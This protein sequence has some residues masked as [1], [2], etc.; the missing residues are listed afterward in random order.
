MKPTEN[1]AKIESELT[2]EGIL[3]FTIEGRL[4]SETTGGLWRKTA[5][6]L[7]RSSPT[8]L[9]VDTTDVG[10]CDGS[11]IALL[12]ELHRR[13]NR[14]GGAFEIRN[15]KP[16]FSR[17]LSFFDSDEFDPSD[18]RKAE[19]D[20]FPEE[21]GKAAYAF[22]GDLKT[23]VAFIGEIA[24]S[25]TNAVLHPRSIRW[26]D[27]FQVMETAGVNALPIIA[28]IGF[29]M[30]LILA[31]QA[32]IPMGQF[33]ADIYVANLVALSMLRELGPLMTAIVLAGR[34][35]SAFAAE[36]GTMKVNEEIDALTTM[37]IDPVR[38]LI[39]PRIIAALVVT[40][41]LAIYADLIGLMG[42]SLVM[43]SL[44]FPLITY[45]NQVISAVTYLD[46]TGGLIKSF[47]FGIVVS[48]IGCFRGLQTRTGASAVGVSTTRSVVTGI[49]LIVFVDG[50]FSIVYY[51]LGI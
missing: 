49:V 13:Q 41:L 21:L 5:E 19:H 37:G 45:I 20:D 30:G 18:T 22:A 14:S 11:G 2:P 3:T 16:E 31:F 40:P 25:L 23:L 36:L 29:I 39:A 7:D 51:Y 10:Y 34:S 26:K 33:G 24:V 9:I 48:A 28:L 47:V 27:V 42:G 1:R 4:D 46:F 8:R 50:I 38:F 43:I 12:L 15:L 32:A 44:G 35:G 17:L 6:A